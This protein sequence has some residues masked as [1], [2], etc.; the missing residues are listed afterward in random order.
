[1]LREFN[2]PLAKITGTRKS[3]IVEAIPEGGLCECCPLA[4]EEVTGN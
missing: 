3:R 4:L 2:Q 1:M